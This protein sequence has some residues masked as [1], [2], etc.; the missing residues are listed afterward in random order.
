MADTKDNTKLDSDKS[1]SKDAEGSKM[2]DVDTEKIRAFRPAQDVVKGSFQLSDIDKTKLPNK[3]WI[4]MALIIIPLGLILSIA[5]LL[6]ALNFN[7][8]DGAGET[9]QPAEE[10]VSLQYASPLPIVTE[11]AQIDP[12]QEYFS[13]ISPNWKDEYITKV[14]KV[15]AVAYQDFLDSDDEDQF[16]AAQDFY[17]YLNNP[18]VI[19]T[20]DQYINFLNDVRD[21]L[22]DQI[23][24]PLY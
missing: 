2:S 22:E 18:S 8:E 4:H 23:G 6:F 9:V 5:I 19:K 13:S 7:F 1:P 3:K 11:Q 10:K 16:Y 24:E 12:L 20:D 15:A 17:V 21:D 14:P